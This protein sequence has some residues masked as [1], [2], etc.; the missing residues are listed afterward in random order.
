MN[1][2]SC[3]FDFEDGDHTCMLPDGHDGSHK[4]TSDDNILVS[5][6]TH[7]IVLTVFD[8]PDPTNDL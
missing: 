2:R 7:G 5:L 3:W 6:D 8:P 4:P 1:E